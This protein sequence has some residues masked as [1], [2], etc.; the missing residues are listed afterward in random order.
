MSGHLPSEKSAF[1]VPNSTLP[2]WRTEVHELDNHRSTE[3]LPTECDVAIIGAGYAG[4]STAYHLLDGNAPPCSIVI[5]EARQACSG[6]TGRNGG[7]LR[8]DFASSAEHI[9]RYGAAAAAEILRFET[10]HIPAIRDIIRREDIDCNF[11]LTKSLAVLLDEDDA[12]H[13]KDAY[14]KLVESGV[15]SSDEVQFVVGNDAELASGVKG[16]KGCLSYNAGHLWPYKF[17]VQLLA[18]VV[19]KGANLQT[20]TPVLHV[21]ES[22]DSKGL[23]TLTTARDSVKAK[24]VVFAS[25]GYTSAIAPQYSQKVVPVRGICSRIVTPDDRPP[26]HMVYTYAISQT[27]GRFDYLIPRADGSIIVGGAKQVFLADRHHWYDVADDSQLIEPAK[28][29]FDG[30]MQRTF[31]GWEDSGA[32]T[33]KVWTGIMGYTSDSLPHIGEVPGKPGQ[34]ILAGFN[35][36]GMPVIFLSAKGIAQMIRDG[37]LYEQS[38][39]PKLFR[40]SRERLESTENEI[41]NTPALKE[42]SV[43]DGSAQ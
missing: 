28:Y 23:W 3:Q 38:G 13:A 14:S 1:P 22:R 30:Y 7:H 29:Y 9:E 33:D 43:P 17:I 11:V 15:A 41:L 24:N 35:G 12:R 32:Y 27:S 25:N 10:S 2:F 16:A 6:A 40:T 4:V 21:S 18:I 42:R 37:K 20:N 36:H 34:F 5:L 8:P 19:A 26:P 39:L 31:T